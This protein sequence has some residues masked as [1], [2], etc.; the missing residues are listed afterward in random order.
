MRNV[1]YVGCIILLVLCGINFVFPRKM[2]IHIFP[3]AC[4]PAQLYIYYGIAAESVTDWINYCI[5]NLYSVG[6]IGG[7]KAGTGST[8]TT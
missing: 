5:Y 6:F 4:I 3:F 8:T 2:Y 1:L 7:F